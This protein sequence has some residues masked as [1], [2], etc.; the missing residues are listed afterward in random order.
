MVGYSAE[1]E[2][3]STAA[4]VVASMSSF[5]TATHNLLGFADIAAIDS[6][7]SF[8]VADSSRLYPRDSRLCYFCCM[9]H[10]A[11]YSCCRCYCLSCSAAAVVMTFDIHYPLIYCSSPTVA[12]SLFSVSGATPADSTRCMSSSNHVAVSFQL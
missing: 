5:G 12:N 8:A 11:G 1:E 2:D 7:R 4:I 10:C 9:T 3:R 6:L